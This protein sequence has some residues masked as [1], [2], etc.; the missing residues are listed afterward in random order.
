MSAKRIYSLLKSNI[1]LEMKYK[2]ICLE[3]KS[4]WAMNLMEFI[5]GI[6]GVYIE[7][8]SWKFVFIWTWK[9]NTGDVIFSPLY[10]RIFLNKAII[11]NKMFSDLGKCKCFFFLY[12][13]IWYIE[14]VTIVPYL[15]VCSVIPISIRRTLKIFR[16]E[17]MPEVEHRRHKI[18]FISSSWKI[19]A[20]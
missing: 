18:S 2:R 1:K 3:N 9:L 6:E 11:S 16:N 14:I 10:F 15:L 17:S 13:F 19:S 5:A 7:I 20:Q 12:L 4:S 8:W